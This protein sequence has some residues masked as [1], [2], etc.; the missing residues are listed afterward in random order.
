MSASERMTD[1]FSGQRDSSWS[2]TPEPLGFTVP[3]M[4]RRI[5]PRGML[6]AF[7]RRRKKR[8]APEDRKERYRQRVISWT[9][10][11]SSS[12]G[13]QS[14]SRAYALEFIHIRSGQSTDL[15]SSIH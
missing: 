11:G 5:D 7:V 10:E 6:R 12:I 8:T 1:S 3:P 9:D 15:V 14:R 4:A 13:V 2:S